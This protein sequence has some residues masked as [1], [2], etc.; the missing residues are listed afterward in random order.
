MTTPTAAIP[1]SRG[2]YMKHRH[3]QRRT[4][5]G[6]AM[7]E[8]VVA[9][10][11]LLLVFMATVELG[12]ALFQYN[13]L[14]KAVRDG[15]RYAASARA[16][17]SGNFELTTAIRNSTV[18]LTVFGNEL[19]VGEPLLPGLT[20]SDVG[21][22]V[23]GVGNGFVEVSAAYGFAPM[24]GSRIPTFGFGEP[25]PISFTFRAASVMRVL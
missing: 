4:Q 2:L 24:L 18:N 7:T 13:A 23:S 11:V 21:V 10:P 5:R 20:K 15:A 16:S 25:I 12:R 17:T 8:F 1:D 9:I 3:T 19:G 6:I 22:Q 14:T